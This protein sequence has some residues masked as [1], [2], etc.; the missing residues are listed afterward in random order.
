M[1]MKAV[2]DALDDLGLPMRQIR[3]RIARVRANLEAEDEAQSVARDAMALE[4]DHWLGDLLSRVSAEAFREAAPQFGLSAQEAEIFLKGKARDDELLFQSLRRIAAA[5]ASGESL[6]ESYAQFLESPDCLPLLGV[7]TNAAG[8][9]TGA[10]VGRAMDFG[11]FIHARVKPRARAEL[12][13]RVM[14]YCEEWADDEFAGRLT[15]EEDTAAAKAL[16]EVAG[17]LEAPEAPPVAAQ[18]A[19]Q[20]VRARFKEIFLAI[21]AIEARDEQTGEMA[22]IATLLPPGLSG[23]DSIGETP[24]WGGADAGVIDLAL[25]SRRHAGLLRLGFVSVGNDFPTEL[26]RS[27][28]RLAATVASV[29][30]DLFEG[31]SRV[32]AV[33]FCAAAFPLAAADQAIAPELAED[34]DDRLKRAGNLVHALSEFSGSQSHPLSN[35]SGFLS[36]PLMALGAPDPWGGLL[37]LSRAK[38]AADPKAAR[39]MLERRGLEAA[40]EIVEFLLADPKR[41]APHSEG[42]ALGQR[43]VMA[44]KGLIMAFGAEPSIAEQIEPLGEVVDRLF[45][46]VRARGG[47]TRKEIANSYLHGVTPE[48]AARMAFSPEEEWIE[49]QTAAAL[50]AARARKAAMGRPRDH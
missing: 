49:K 29:G 30:A 26:E 27:M 6:P 40:M 19:A 5:R 12:F 33:R 9:R 16:R 23:R 18:E 37:A 31:V 7:A 21:E 47:F 1:M 10:G 11:P 39:S 45:V 34:M 35:P 8:G 32:E 24:R 4:L 22:L 2:Q 44:A 13:A 28:L 25:R 38:A 50:R 20:A 17:R 36:L 43:A 48:L 42:D 15:E 3:S 14:L 46:A 41:V